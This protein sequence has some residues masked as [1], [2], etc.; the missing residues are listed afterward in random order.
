MGGSTKTDP[1]GCLFSLLY[2]LG[3][4]SLACGSLWELNPA[5]RITMQKGALLISLGFVY[6]VALTE[7]LNKLILRTSFGLNFVKRYRLRISDVLDI[8]NK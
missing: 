6:F 8:T 3:S 7:F 2:S 5:D 4:F 1:K